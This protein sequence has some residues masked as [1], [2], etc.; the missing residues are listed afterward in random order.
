[1]DEIFAPITRTL[2]DVILPN[3]KAVQASQAEQVSANY[4][5]EDA[6]EELRLHLASQFALLSTQLTACRAELAAA[7]AMFEAVQQQKGAV[8][9]DRTAIVH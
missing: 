5:L 2:T 8:E 3:L 6:I 1:M 7:Q 4:R 9:P